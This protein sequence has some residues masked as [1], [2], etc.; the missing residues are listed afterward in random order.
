MKIKELR[1]LTP[2]DTMIWIE[3]AEEEHLE[4]G[5]NKYLSGEYDD[6][7]IGRMYPQRYRAFSSIGITVQI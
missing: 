5:E 1:D 6:Y 3:T 4:H 7:D 2:E